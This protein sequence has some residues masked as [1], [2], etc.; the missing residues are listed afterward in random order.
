MPRTF[1]ERKCVVCG[2]TDERGC[3]EGCEW[4]SLAPPVCSLCVREYL[5][6]KIWTALLEL[7]SLPSRK[8]HRAVEAARMAYSFI[9]KE[10]AERF[11]LPTL[12]RIRQIDRNE[13]RWSAKQTKKGA[14]KRAK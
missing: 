8:A 13:K 14:P 6:A 5:V 11:G 2:C 9:T 3:D 1:D 12:R 4:I 7:E 10:R